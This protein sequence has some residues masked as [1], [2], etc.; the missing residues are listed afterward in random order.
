VEADGLPPGPRT[1]MKAS[2]E[3]SHCVF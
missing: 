1:T 2:S 3:A